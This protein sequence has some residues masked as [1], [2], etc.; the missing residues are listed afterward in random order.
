MRHA[1]KE[2]FPTIYQ[3]S[4]EEGQRYE[5]AAKSQLKKVQKIWAREHAKNDEK[6][7]KLQGDEDK[8]AKNLEEA[9]TIVI[10][11]DKSL[12]E[13]KSIKIREAEAHR[14]VRVK[15]YGWVHRLR[16]QGCC[17]FLF[18]LK[19]GVFLFINLLIY[20]F[21]RKVVDVRYSEGWH[22]IPAVRV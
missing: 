20:C 6:Q 16:R 22:W 12:P 9:K 8:R 3:D 13:A 21:Y 7:R 2:P 17:C 11:E 1:G 18:L 14:D 19:K 4:N 15:I 5:P 10:E